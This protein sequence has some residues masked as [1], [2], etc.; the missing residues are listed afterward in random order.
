MTEEKQTRF[1]NFLMG[2][3]LDFYEE[4]IV[5][6]TDDEQQSCYQENPEF[7]SEYAINEKRIALLRDPSYRGI[8]RKVKDMRR[9][10]SDGKS[11]REMSNVW[12]KGTVE[13]S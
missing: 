3:D 12:R 2:D 13:K 5:N 6:L 11:T 10:E 8:L 1:L 9:N 7:M 4:Y